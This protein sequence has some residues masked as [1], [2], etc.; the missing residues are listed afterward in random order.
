MKKTLIL[1]LALT[2]L[3]ASSC[4]FIRQVAGR[5]TAA[6]VEALRQERLAR[7]EARHQATLDSLEQVRRHMEDSLAALE[8]HLLDSLSQAK[9]TVLNPSKMGGL[10]TTKLEA[11]YCIVVGAFRTRA[12]AER[13]LNKCNEAGYTATIIS[14]RNG[15][16]AVSVCPSN[17]LNEV[18]RTLRQLRGKG[19]CPEDGWILVNE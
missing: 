8:A 5:P 12:Y 3:A 11:K 4:D 17:D 10:F 19:I 7:E 15:L 2:A 6:E 1:M 14:F 18:L 13:K 9:G 16:L